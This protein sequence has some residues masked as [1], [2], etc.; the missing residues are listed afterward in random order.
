MSISKKVA[1]SLGYRIGRRLNSA[2]DLGITQ[3]EFVIRSSL[4]NA[5]KNIYS[6]EEQFRRNFE[7]A[8][9]K[10]VHYKGDFAEDFREYLESIEKNRRDFRRER[11]DYGSTSAL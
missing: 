11:A 8:R 7:E 3:R 1:I 9:T 6:D 10:V 2:F 4:D 5:R